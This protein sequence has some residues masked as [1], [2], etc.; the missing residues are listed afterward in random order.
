MGFDHDYGSGLSKAKP[1]GIIYIISG[2]R[3]AKLY[4]PEQ[5]SDPSTWLSFTDKFLSEQNSFNVVDIGGK[6]LR[7]KQVSVTGKELDSFLYRA[8]F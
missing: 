8:E 5:Q 4:N 6:T 7:L 3:G 1:H 2:A